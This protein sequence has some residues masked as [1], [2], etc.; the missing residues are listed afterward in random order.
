MID[1]SSTFKNDDDAHLKSLCS[2]RHHYF[3]FLEADENFE[4]TFKKLDFWM[5]TWISLI[6]R[7]AE[8][9]T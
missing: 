3:P 1:G 4:K 8:F 5:M 2:V 9:E 6:S 7:T